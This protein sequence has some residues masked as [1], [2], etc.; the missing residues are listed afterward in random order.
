[1]LKVVAPGFETSAAISL[2]IE[3]GATKDHRMELVPSKDGKPET[4]EKKA[5][6]TLSLEDLGGKSKPAA[7]DAKDD[8]KDDAKADKG[9][10]TAS[11][12][13]SAAKAADKPADKPAA[14]DDKAEAAASDKGMINI[15]STPPVNVV[16]DG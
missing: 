7:D 4:A 13:Q 3:G 1:F 12:T 11:K 10:A 9:S 15:S 6:E 2:Q 16:V 5:D 8:S 14:K